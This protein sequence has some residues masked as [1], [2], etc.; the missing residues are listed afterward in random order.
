MVVNISTNKN[1]LTIPLPSVT[2]ILGKEVEGRNSDKLLPSMLGLVVKRHTRHSWKVLPCKRFTSSI[3]V[4]PSQLQG[5][6]VYV[7]ATL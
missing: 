1:P 4:Q 2:L 6:D 3:L 7:L 5:G